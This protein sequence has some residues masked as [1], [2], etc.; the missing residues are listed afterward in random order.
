VVI[1]HGGT[2]PKQTIPYDRRKRST[3]DV[4]FRP[5]SGAHVVLAGR[6]TVN[7]RHVEFRTIRTTVWTTLERAIDVTFRSVTTARFSIQGSRSVRVLGGSAGPASDAS[8]LI[9]AASTTARK[10]PVGI[11]LDRVKIQGYTRTGPPGSVGCLDV[12]AASGLTIR[13]SRL[14]DC[15]DFGLRFSAG[16]YTGTPRNVVVENNLFSCCR[17]GSRALYLDDE[18]TPAWEN[19]SIRNNSLSG[20]VE[21]GSGGSAEHVA[22][23]SNIALSFAGCGAAGALVDYNVWGTGSSCG[24][25]DTVAPSGFADPAAQ[26]FDLLPDAAAIDHGSLATAPAVDI[27]GQAR[28]LGAAADAGAKESRSSGLVAAYPFNESGGTVAP[29]ASALDNDGA[30]TGASWTSSGRFGGAL[31]FDGANDWVTVLDDPSL[32]L[33]DS[34]TLEAWV[35]P[36]TLGSVWRT[37]MMK[38]QPGGLSY[39]IYGDTSSGKPSGNVNVGTELDTRAPSALRLNTWTHLTATY[40]GATLRLFVNGKQVSSRTVAGSLTTSLSALRIGGNAVWDEWFDGAIDEVR[41]YRRALSAG[42]V[43]RDMKSPIKLAVDSAPPSAPTLFA[44]T[45]ATATSISVAWSPA[46]DDTGVAGYGLYK[47]GTLNGTTGSASYTFTGLTCGT[48]YTLAVDAYDAAGNR[49]AQASISA[50]TSDCPLPDTEAPAAP[51]GLVS[52]ASTATSLSVTWTPSTDNVAVTGYALFRDGA[53]PGTTAGTSY[54]FASLLC[55][56]AYTLGVEAFDAAGNHSPRATLSVSTSGCPPPDTSP[57]TTPT[58]LGATAATETSISV[59]W[60]ASTDNVGISGYGLYRN[61][62]NTGSTAAGT[63]T[64]TFGSLICATS[65]TL[66]VDAYDAAGNRSGKASL[67]ASTSACSPP[68][69]GTANLWV[70]ANGGTC[71][72]DAGHTYADGTACGSFDAA[73]D[74]C[75]N[76]D[77]VLVKGGTYSDQTVTGS[78]GRTS[79][80]TIQGVSGETVDFHTLTTSGNWLTAGEMMSDTGVTEHLGVAGCS[81]CNTGSHVTLDNVDFPGKWAAIEISGGDS[82]TWKNS[83]LGTP[84]NTADRLCGEDDE[85]ARMSNATNVVIDH[86]VF[87]PFR[88]EENPGNCG[89]DVYHLETWRLWDSNDGVLFSNNHFDDSNGDDSFTISSSMGGCQDCPDNKNLQFVNNY[90]GDKCC[91]YAGADI[92]FG[93]GRACTGFVFAYN[94]FHSGGAGLF[95]NCSSESGMVYVGNLGYNP[96]GCPVSGTNTA[97]LWIGT[98]H[99][100]CAGN[101]W[102]SGGPDNWSSYRLSADGLHLTG[103]SPSVNGGETSFCATWTSRLDIDGQAR[104]GNCDVGP[105]EYMP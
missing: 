105:D 69:S 80:C 91:G 56:T 41:V 49:S 25:N 2:Y 17:A 72:R 11:T 35:N 103:S 34:L 100:T 59:S 26:D 63:R 84:G 101:T 14:F 62:T 58:G 32:D 4:I 66:E 31:S 36:R 42:E 89:G 99:G 50:A 38:E 18:T 65:Y 74:K 22:V 46:T 76:G 33:A 93:D 51:T 57:P 67:S 43:A 83:E 55:E 28:P 54:T 53:S 60:N 81:W 5:A 52:I 7:G 90:F 13:N 29:D 86:N 92:G 75:Q 47:G 12:R 78:N 6:L 95:N 27:D 20:S 82:V 23:Y 104:S 48:T 102:M 70:D 88:G 77:L 16:P 96:G 79:A 97:N 98:T 30:V 19:L 21:I 40:D 73:N 24:P 1:V 3:K 10:P 45:G 71:V 61:G 85:P 87:H 9:M 44:A 94:F 8:N 68:T 39:G 64:Y 15:E 37:V